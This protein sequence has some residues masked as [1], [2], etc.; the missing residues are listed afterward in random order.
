L[1]FLE[2]ETIHRIGGTRLGRGSPA[3]LAAMR[4]R[5]V[6]RWAVAALLLVRRCASDDD[7]DVLRLGMLV[8]FSALRSSDAARSRISEFRAV[9]YANGEFRSIAVA[10]IAAARHFNERNGTVVRAFAEELDGCGVTIDFGARLWDTAAEPR[11]TIETYGT[12]RAEN[13]GATPFDAV[14]GPA[15]SASSQSLATALTIERVL[16]MS[17]WS[18]APALDDR[19]SYPYFVPR[20]RCLF[21]FIS[22]LTGDR[23]RG[24]SRATPSSPPRRSGSSTPT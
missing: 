19:I 24:R 9:R 17:Y 14:V 3:A 16:V 2:T 15:R 8:P 10:M 7:A 21:L 1:N 18:T 13:G 6:V 5:S 11:G 20:L 12:A 23:R 22:R 4:A